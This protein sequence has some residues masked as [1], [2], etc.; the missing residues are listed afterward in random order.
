[1]YCYITKVV[2]GLCLHAHPLLGIMLSL[3]GQTDVTLLVDAQRQSSSRPHVIF[4]RILLAQSYTKKCKSTF[5]MCLCFI[6]T[7]RCTRDRSHMS[8]HS[9]NSYVWSHECTHET[10]FCQHL[11][12]IPMCE[13]TYIQEQQNA[14]VQQRK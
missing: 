9:V 8:V 10:G 2:M 11:Q 1:M 3:L 5:T 12:N 14:H 4:K 7:R 13:C 6:H